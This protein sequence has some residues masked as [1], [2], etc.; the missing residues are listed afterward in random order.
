M[1]KIV[2]SVIVMSGLISASL[3]EA[4]DKIEVKGCL[5]KRTHPLKAEY[6]TVVT[7]IPLKNEPIQYNANENEDYIKI[8]G[9]N[10]RYNK[11]IINAYIKCNK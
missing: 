2:L 10:L 3:V 9:F 7:Y 11:K 5:I 8:N 6:G 4:S 1:K